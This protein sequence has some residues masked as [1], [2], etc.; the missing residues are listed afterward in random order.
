MRARCG[1]AH[2]RTE[3]R[4]VGKQARQEGEASAHAQDVVSVRAELREGKLKVKYRSH[5]S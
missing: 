1:R 2:V 4:N 5:L 3:R